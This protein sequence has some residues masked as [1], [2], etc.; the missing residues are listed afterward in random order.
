MAS[1]FIPKHSNCQTGHGETQ[2]QCQDSIVAVIGPARSG[3][4]SFVRLVS[5]D[6]TF[7]SR[8]GP[9]SQAYNIDFA[10]YV[11]ED[12]RRVTLLDTPGFY[13]PGRDVTA[14]DILNS[15]ASFLETEFKN[16]TKLDGVI[17][18]RSIATIGTPDGITRREV[19]MLQK[20]CGSNELK[21]MI[22]ATTMG[23][24]EDKGIGGRVQYE[25]ATKDDFLKPLLDDGARLLCHNNGF[26]S[27]RVIMSQLLNVP[28]GLSTE[29]RNSDVADTVFKAGP[30]RQSTYHQFTA[31]KL[32]ASNGMSP[33]PPY[34][35][36]Y[37]PLHSP[38]ASY[39]K[40][41]SYPFLSTSPSPCS[42]P[43][44]ASFPAQRSS[45]PSYLSPAR[46]PSPFQL[47]SPT[48]YSPASPVLQSHLTY[49][50]QT[51]D[52]DTAA[53]IGFGWGSSRGPASQSDALWKDW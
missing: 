5:G 9:K 22:I 31:E 35:P 37:S 40:H 33:P 12:G 14:T 17:Y 24:A 15:I 51:G 32:W 20:L 16:K 29:W 36:P 3:K 42:T 27:A 6:G 28:L 18:M 38:H 48:R 11:E 10:T 34:S 25:L 47:S 50:A 45:S 8:C 52:P 21:N 1:Y 19:K 43:A 41:L 13:G 39:P 7:Q 46:Y 4:S 53:S 49:V 26:E 30:E 23:D 2:A 44:Q